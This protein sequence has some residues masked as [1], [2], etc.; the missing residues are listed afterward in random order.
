MG[1][2]EMIYEVR[3]D[4]KVLAQFSSESKAKKEMKRLRKQHV[5]CRVYSRWIEASKVKEEKRPK[6]R[7][8]K[9][10]NREARGVGVV[11]K[12]RPYTMVNAYL[13][14]KGMPLV[15]NDMTFQDLYT[16]IVVDLRTMEGTLGECNGRKSA[17]LKG[18]EEAM[19]HPCIT[20]RYL[21][22]ILKDTERRHARPE[23]SERWID[24]MGWTVSREAAEEFARYW[25]SLNEPFFLAAFRNGRPCDPGIRDS[26]LSVQPT[27]SGLALCYREIEDRKVYFVLKDIDW[28]EIKGGKLEIFGRLKD[29]SQAV[30]SFGLDVSAVHKPTAEIGFREGWYRVNKGFLVFIQ[31]SSERLEEEYRGEYDG[32]IDY[33]A[34]YPQFSGYAMDGGLIAHRTGQSEEEFLKENFDARD[35]EYIETADPLLIREA[36]ERNDATALGRIK[37]RYPEMAVVS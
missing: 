29:G 25:R 14:T 28:V 19:D 1:K 15:R 10:P 27:D 11:G 26:D 3:S 5:S 18:I 20:V 4:G 37:S 34:V 24:S 17:L 2:T 7:R 35:A 8:K 32:Y 33:S 13:S 12:V 9:S 6:F 22:G 16:A 36:F 31:R 30:R 23:P 21:E